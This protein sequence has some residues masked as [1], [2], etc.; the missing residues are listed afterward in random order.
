M[1]PIIQRQVTSFGATMKAVPAALRATAAPR[2]WSSLSHRAK[3]L[4]NPLKSGH[5]CTESF[6]SW[7]F[8]RDDFAY[9]IPKFLKRRRLVALAIHLLKNLHQMIEGLRFVA[10]KPVSATVVEK[11]FNVFVHYRC[12]PISVRSAARRS[13]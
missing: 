2:V 3:A 4:D 1:S 7:F 13:W 9:V 5:N 11:A 6:D 12:S 10:A 8:S